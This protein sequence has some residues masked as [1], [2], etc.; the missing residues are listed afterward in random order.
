MVGIVT[1]SGNSSNYHTLVPPVGCSVVQM[2][3]LQ[4]DVWPAH[5]AF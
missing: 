5:C 2:A 4:Q 3:S 1:S